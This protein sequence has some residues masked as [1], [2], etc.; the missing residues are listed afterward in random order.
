MCNTNESNATEVVP[1]IIFFVGMSASGSPDPPTP[2]GSSAAVRRCLR[3][4]VPFALDVGA[5]WAGEG[6]ELA[7]E[8]VRLLDDDDAGTRAAWHVADALRQRPRGAAPP[9]AG[10]RLSL[11]AVG[12]RALLSVLAAAL[13]GGPLRTLALPACAAVPAGA[14]AAALAAAL[15]AAPAASASALAVVDLRRCAVHDRALADLAGILRAACPHLRTLRLAANRRISAAGL[16][17]LADAL[18]GSPALAALSLA[19]CAGVGPA[20]A[21]QVARLLAHPASRLTRLDLAGCRIGDFGVRALADAAVAGP[22]AALLELSLCANAIGD[23]GAADLADALA[24]LSSL[25]VLD[26]ADNAV[27]AKGLRRL[28]ASL[29]LLGSAAA[30]LLDLNLARNP[31]ASD[32]AALGLADAVAAALRSAA[33]T[34]SA[35]HTDEPMHFRCV[36]GA[37]PAARL[38]SSSLPAAAAPTLSFSGASVTEVHDAIDRRFSPC[39]ADWIEIAR[40]AS[41]MPLRRLNGCF[42]A[43]MDGRARLHAAITSARRLDRGG[44]RDRAAADLIKHTELLLEA[45]PENLPLLGEWRNKLSEM[46]P[47]RFRRPLHSKVDAAVWADVLLEYDRY[48]GGGFKLLGFDPDLHALGIESL[49]QFLSD[50]PTEEDMQSARAELEFLL[51]ETKAY[52]SY[53]ESMRSESSCL[54]LCRRGLRDS[55]NGLDDA[56]TDRLA[57]S[58]IQDKEAA[59][60]VAVEKL[61]NAQRSVRNLVIEAIRLSTGLYP[62]LNDS[63][64]FVDGRICDYDNVETL[65]RSNSNHVVKVAMDPSVQPPRAVVLKEFTLNHSDLARMMNEVE[66]IQRISEADGVVKVLKMFREQDRAFMVMPRY[67]FGSLLQWVDQR[68]PPTEV[69]FRAAYRLACALEH[70]HA[71]SVVH[72]DLKPENIFFDDDDL[73]VIGDFDFSK[74][75]ADRTTS[76]FTISSVYSVHGGTLNYM[77]PEVS[78]TSPAT[79]ASDVYSLGLVFIDLFVGEGSK[80]R[81]PVTVSGRVPVELRELIE[82][83]LQVDAGRRPRASAIASSPV[84]RLVHTL[85]TKPIAPSYWSRAALDGRLPL[86][87]DVTDPLNELVQALIDRTAAAGSL[88]V[89]RVERLETATSFLRY[90]A[91]CHSQRISGDSTSSSFSAP[92]PPVETADWIASEQYALDD[93][94]G[95]RW[96]LHSTS[97]IANALQIAAVGFVGQRA[98]FFDRADRADGDA[99]ASD[100]SQRCGAAAARAMLLC[101]VVLGAC[102]HEGTSSAELPTQSAHL[103]SGSP[104]SAVHSMYD[105][106]TARFR[107]L[108]GNQAYAQFLIHY[109]KC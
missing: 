59:V 26:L 70:I 103:Q 1:E 54:E 24:A 92:Y 47:H 27:G 99:E 17:H 18:A 94:I 33:P 36:R 51:S 68:V 15:R 81:G 11:C 100:L 35:V 19:A 85:A 63:T 109:K 87:F 46:R 106:Q 10:L 95:E 102:V 43:V 42:S 48:S 82:S 83:M 71:A 60:V 73:P 32:V 90:R 79:Y 7:L 105:A 41:A 5:L 78:V 53:L 97:S 13:D 23:A 50:L 58:V 104:S 30:P 69:R 16:G 31:V 4:G 93:S 107:V 28:A 61:R 8:G 75:V 20:G 98:S 64:G 84:F 101:R 74:S 67:R 86:R 89:E 21:A 56:R 52:A 9:L 45:A 22:A 65:E 66:V 25:R 80:S 38:A 108:D 57:P 72:C 14:A 62:E 77:A 91:V 96:L 6:G 2:C 88:R 76:I 34:D 37:D 39:C 49:F 3:D 12:A 40:L 29:M 55:R 44:I